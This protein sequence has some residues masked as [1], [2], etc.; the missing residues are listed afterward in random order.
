MHLRFKFSF[1]ILSNYIDNSSCK[2]NTYMPNLY[3]NQNF[4]LQRK[5][6]ISMHLVV[7]LLLWIFAHAIQ[8]QFWRCSS[9][10]QSSHSR[11]RSKK[12]VQFEELI[13]HFA[14]KAEMTIFLNMAVLKGPAEW[15]KKFKALWYVIAQPL[16]YFT[17]IF[18]LLLYYFS[19]F[20]SLCT[21]QSITIIKWNTSGICE[22]C[23]YHFLKSHF[24]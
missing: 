17:H 3:S 8:T 4:A 2:Y 14:T 21:I 5:I 9:Q 1:K 10:H 7:V 15:I 16:I 19:I 24:V 6:R 18:H 20:D 13:E 12:K 23:T 22:G 11:L